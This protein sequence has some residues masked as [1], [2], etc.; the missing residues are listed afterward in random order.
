MKPSEAELIEAVRYAGRQVADSITDMNASP[1]HDAM[2]GSVRCLT[3]AMIGVSNSLA[4]IA[5]AIKDLAD[6]VRDR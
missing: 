1:G 2:G 5:G 6:A 4:A 3:E